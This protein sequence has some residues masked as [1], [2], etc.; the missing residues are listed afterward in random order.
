M[1]QR[2][3]T[4]AARRLFSSTAGKESANALKEVPE[5]AEGAVSTHVFSADGAKTAARGGVWAGI[6]ALVGLCG[7][8]ITRELFPTSLS[9][10]H[11][12]NTSF[13]AIREHDEVV[14]RLG[15]PVKAYGRDHGGH[16]EGRRNFVSHDIYNDDDGLPHCRVKYTLE[17][18]KGK[19]NLYADVKKGASSGSFEYIILERHMRGRKEAIALIDNRVHLTREMIQEKVATRLGSLKDTALFGREDCQWTLRQK[20]ELGDFFHLVKYYAC[21]KGENKVAC[22]NAQL[23][24]YPTWRFTGQNVPGFKPVEELQVI[25]RQL[26]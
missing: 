20:A 21:D 16:R 7:Y 3:S 1:P 13:D 15:S 12:F 26:N 4:P 19:A 5:G 22:E 6:A 17:G 8:Y 10:N 14:A 23:K 2:A 11:V 25:A 24:G 9:P 18:P